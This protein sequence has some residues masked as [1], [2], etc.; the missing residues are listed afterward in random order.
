M[1]SNLAR[2]APASMGKRSWMVTTSAIVGDRVSSAARRR[3]AAATAG[4]WAGV[5]V[6][7]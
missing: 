1:R 3:R 5:S 6:T 4:T 7:M 2:C